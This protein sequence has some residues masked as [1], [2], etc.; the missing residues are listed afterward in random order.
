M[1]ENNNGIISLTQQWVDSIIIGLQLCPFA[2]K[3]FNQH[4]IFYTVSNAET[5]E[6]RID[7]LINECHRLDNDRKIETTLLIYKKGLNDFFDY[8]Q[9]I[10][11]ANSV[12]K[13]NGWQGIY[14]IASFHPRYVF[15]NTS[16]NDRENYTNRA[17]YPIIH[18]LREQTL[19][20]AIKN[21]P[22]TD[23]IPEKNIATMNAL[24]DEKLRS[25]FYYLWE[26]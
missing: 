20:E 13:K 16:P 24:S 15:A 26:R 2:K 1:C 23:A 22:N 10:E 5:N 21:F 14:Q 17:P 19:E 11:W 25:I 12:L 8:S 7:E 4:S 3:P 9:F 6:K 18:L